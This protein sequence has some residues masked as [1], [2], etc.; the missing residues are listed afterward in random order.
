MT[1]IFEYPM[2]VVL[3]CAIALAA[4]MQS[5]AA[6]LSAAD[7]SKSAQDK[8]IDIA[9]E[10]F[11]DSPDKIRQRLMEAKSTLHPGAFEPR[12]REE[13]PLN[14]G[15]R[16]RGLVAKV[17]F[18]FDKKTSPRTGYNYFLIYRDQAAAVKGGDNEPDAVPIIKKID[19]QRPDG[20]VMEVNCQPWS[21]PGGIG[22]RCWRVEPSLP[23]V[24][25]GAI[26]E[27]QNSKTQKLE[28]SFADP[29]NLLAV[30]I[31]FL[32]RELK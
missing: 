15:E 31:N 9:I 13:L 18:S 26:E 29:A 1:N 28:S 30:A 14:D 19:L 11:K 2:R 22:A 17:R 16:R 27:R 23:V 20:S 3:V 32:H 4:T 25:V 24:V 10:L 7:S 21:P 5:P 6:V 8:A 12:A